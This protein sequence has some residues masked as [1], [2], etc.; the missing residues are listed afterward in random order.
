LSPT[1]IREAR[2]F[3]PPWLRKLKTKKTK[4][5]IGNR[6]IFGGGGHELNLC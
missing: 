2:T 3:G 1:G 4:K 6:L 5:R